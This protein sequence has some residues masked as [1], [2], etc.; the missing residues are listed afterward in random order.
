MGEIDGNRAKL[1]AFLEEYKALYRLAEFRMNA[2]DRR[3]A[4]T[5]GTLASFVAVV[6]AVPRESQL[7]VLV[8]IPLMLVWFMRATVNHARSFEDILRRIEEIEGEV[9]ALVDAKAM[10][11]QSRHPSGHREVGGRTGRESVRSVLVTVLLLLAACG[12]QFD[13]LLGNSTTAFGLY[14]IYLAV[15]GMVVTVE[16]IRLSQYAYSPQIRVAVSED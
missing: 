15:V 5:G 3:V 10:T 9:N 4:V 14:V 2:M 1:S 8:G 12:Y 6:A 13:V 11:F 16:R 7:L